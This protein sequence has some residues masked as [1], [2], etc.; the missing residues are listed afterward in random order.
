[1]LKNSQNITWTVIGGNCPELIVR[2]S[3]ILSGN[4]PGGNCQGAI[5]WGAIIQKKIVLEPAQI[6]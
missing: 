3:V 1:M 5:F 6:D 4:F 2:G